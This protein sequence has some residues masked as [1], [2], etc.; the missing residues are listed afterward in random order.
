MLHHLVLVSK[1]F[2]NLFP[3]SRE[4][5]MYSKVADV[6]LGFKFLECAQKAVFMASGFCCQP[7]KAQENKWHNEILDL[8]LKNMLSVLTELFSV[9]GYSWVQLLSFYVVKRAHCDSAMQ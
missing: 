6:S 4:A 9:P 5:V 8:Y 1:V 2:S 7:V 3:L